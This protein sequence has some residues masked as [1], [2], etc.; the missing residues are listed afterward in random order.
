M[1]R[2]GGLSEEEFRSIK[3]KLIEPLDQSARN[4]QGKV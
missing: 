2:E 3:S 4:N 1:H